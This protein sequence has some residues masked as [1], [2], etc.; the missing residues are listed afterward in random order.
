MSVGILKTDHRVKEGISVCV[1]IRKNEA[2]DNLK[3]NETTV[4]LPA[5]TGKMLEIFTCAHGVYVSCKDG[6]FLRF[7]TLL[8]SPVFQD[9]TQSELFDECG[10]K[11]LLNDVFQ[12]FNATLFAYGREFSEI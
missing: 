1:R 4:E 5:S 12:G 9:Q 6:E 10:V 11:T 2:D 7:P 8:A 3:H